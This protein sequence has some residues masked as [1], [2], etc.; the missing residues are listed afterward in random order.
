M[1]DFGVTYNTETVAFLRRQPTMAHYEQKTDSREFEVA[2]L[3]P[4][5]GRPIG[6]SREMDA[7][8]LTLRIWHAHGSDRAIPLTWDA[9][10]VFVYMI[11]DLVAA[12][13][14]RVAEELRGVMTAH[15]D[16]PAAAL[17]AAKRIQMAS[18]EFVACRP[19]DALAVAV[20]LSRPVTAGPTGLK[21]EVQ[22]ALGL[23]K[24]GQILL[25]D[26]PWRLPDIPGKFEFRAVPP[27][28]S[29]TGEAQIALKE[30]LW[31]P[32]GQFA[33]LQSRAGDLAQ[34]LTDEN[35]PANATVIVSPSLLGKV[36]SPL[37]EP[38]TDEPIFASREE[39]AGPVD[40]PTSDRSN[41]DSPRLDS[42]ADSEAGRLDPGRL[43]SGHV[44]E[45]S[46][47]P[48]F[49]R[50]RI[51]FGAVAVVIVASLTAVFYHP[52]RV[53]KPP[54]QTQQSSPASADGGSN[55]VVVAPKPPPSTPPVKKQE[56]PVQAQTA[57]NPPI[58]KQP[59]NK[60]AKPEEAPPPV[61]VDGFSPKDI[62]TLLQVA[63]NDLGAGNYDKARREYGIVARLQPG[64]PD[65]KQGLHRLDIIQSQNRQ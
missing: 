4:Q 29:W 25:E 10:S 27:L 56:K 37:P 31:T 54:E 48:F 33:A 32:P 44:E 20:L 43:G 42:P 8:D 55:N 59:K 41:F 16:S 62:Q 46:E 61:N 5:P 23:A 53:S 49:T 14:G 1:A 36:A 24:P 60:K 6:D 52:T 50:T 18:S 11:A 2:K 13:R 3:D 57:S 12:S 65:A 15:F 19:A 21:P 17:V 58:E 30:L 34:S 40:T 22:Q 28:A 64:N 51:I 35:L 38:I 39:R 9:D 45:V 7:T 47:T 63:Q 26:I